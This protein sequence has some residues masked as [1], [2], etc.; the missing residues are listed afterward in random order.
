MAAIAHGWVPPASS[1]IHIPV[2]VAKE[3]NA[4]DEA[5]A[6]RRKA[7]SMGQQQV[8]TAMLKRRARG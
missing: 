6:A 3:F 7:P 2:S 1:G 8:A 4:A 5:V